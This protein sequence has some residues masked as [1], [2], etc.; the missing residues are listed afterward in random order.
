[1]YFHFYNEC[2]TSKFPDF[3]VKDLVID[4]TTQQSLSEEDRHVF[5]KL[6][7]NL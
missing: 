7:V 1:M 6:G 2:V 5:L 3:K 4:H